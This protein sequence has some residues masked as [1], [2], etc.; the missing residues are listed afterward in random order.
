VDGGEYTLWQFRTNE[1]SAIYSGERGH[2][3]AFYSIATDKAG[4]VEPGPIEPDI[5]VIVSE[6]PAGAG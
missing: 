4:N 6:L 1:T 5:Q 3:Y 2:T